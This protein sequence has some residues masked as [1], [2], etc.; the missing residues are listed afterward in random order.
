[1]RGNRSY[2]TKPEAAVRSILHRRGFRF[3]KHLRP[4]RDLRCTADIVFSRE[5]TAVFIDGCFWHGC[6][7]HGHEP[8]RNREFWVQK[9][10]GNQARDRRNDAELTKAGW[11][12]IRAWEH[13]TAA[14]VATQII[15]A[16]KE[17]RGQVSDR[18]GVKTKRRDRR[19]PET[20]VN[21]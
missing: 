20:T 15:V 7:L 3:R 1:M 5:Q 21:S 10:R 8:T 11:L 16:L 12:V 14:D 17:R 9:V 19:N 18:A 13:E 2:D 6:P 4:L